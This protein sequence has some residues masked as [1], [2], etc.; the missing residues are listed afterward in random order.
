[1][2]GTMNGCKRKA[3]GEVT[4]TTMTVVHYSPSKGMNAVGCKSKKP[5]IDP[6]LPL[7]ACPS[8]IIVE[9]HQHQQHQQEEEEEQACFNSLPREVFYNIVAYLGPTSTS[10]THL[11]QLN[12]EYKSIMT[13][14]GDVMLHRAQLQCRTPL[15]ANSP[16]ESSIS[17]FVRHARVSKAIQ[18]KLEVLDNVLKKD[19]LSTTESTVISYEDSRKIP[20]QAHCS[21]TF[22]CSNHGRKRRIVQPHEVLNALDIALCLLGCTVHHYFTNI[23]D[24]KE[25]TTKRAAKIAIERRVSNLCSKIGAKAYNYAKSRMFRRQE[26]EDQVFSAYYNTVTTSNGVRTGTDDDEGEVDYDDDDDDISIDPSEQ[27]A[28]EDMHILDKACLVM[29]YVVLRQQQTFQLH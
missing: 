26:R 11:S 13:S 9:Q 25:V 10:L 1:M 21:L 24:P 15:L 29:Q 4:T 14:L 2:D 19:F 3:V 12:H 28:N 23:N 27:E 7:S 5:C 16:C 22:E 17:L 6:P 18:D 20:M 8:W